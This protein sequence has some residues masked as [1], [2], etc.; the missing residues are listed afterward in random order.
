MKKNFKVLITVVVIIIDLGTLTIINMFTGNPISNYI[1]TNNAKEYIKNNYSNYDYYIKSVNYNFKYG[2]YQ[3]FIES[4][5]SKDSS[6]DLYYNHIGKKESDNYN[7]RVTMR[8]NTFLRLTEEYGKLTKEVLEKLP[9][10]TKSHYSIIKTINDENNPIYKDGINLET[11][12][13]DNNYD[14][15]VLGK[16]FGKISINIIEENIDNNKIMDILIQIR[17]LFDDK[18]VKFKYIDLT[19]SNENNKDNNIYVY[20]FLYDNINE[21]DKDIKIKQSI[22]QTKK[23]IE[24]L[25]KQK[26]GGK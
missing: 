13:L 2:Q 11:L 6:F 12:I 10:N 4:P 5:T 20:D 24:I 22:E 26:S 7:F 21:E 23:A 16:E 25:E 17:K 19:I 1:V 15:S 9:F 8:S 14:I 18:D 3:V